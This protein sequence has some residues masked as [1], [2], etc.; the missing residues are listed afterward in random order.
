[1]RRRAF[2]FGLKHERPYA[3]LFFHTRYLQLEV[4]LDQ[5]PDPLPLALSHIQ[6]HLELLMQNGLHIVSAMPNWLVMAAPLFYGDGGTPNPPRPAPA[7]QDLV[8]GESAFHYWHVSPMDSTFPLDPG[9]AEN[10]QVVILDTAQNPDRV[11]AASARPEFRRNPLLQNL[12]EN[13]RRE[14]GSFAIE[15][16]RYPLTDQVHGGRDLNGDPRYYRI[17]DHGLFLAGL[18]R[19]IAPRVPIRLIRMLNDYGGSDLY[20]LYAVLSDLERELSNGSIARLVLNLSITIMPDIRRLPY[21]WLE[22]RQWHSNL[23]PGALRVLDHIEEGLRLLFQ[24]IAE[25]DVL[26]VASA[27]NDSLVANKQDRF[28]RPPRAP[29]RYNSTLSVASVNSLEQGSLFSNTANIAPYD[30]G[31]ATFGGEMYGA[32]DPQ[33][34]PDAVRGL[35]ISSIFPGGEQN[36]TAWA[37]WS[38]TSFSTGIISAL[39]AHL[40]AQGWSASQVRSRL[41]GG[42]NRVSESVFGGPPDIPRL[43]ANVLRVQQR[44]I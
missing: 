35:Y 8:S 38:G 29:A 4:S 32:A 13:L 37:D 16:D 18:I 27:G 10:V 6:S 3:A 42:Y 24:C 14:N 31:I 21:I 17:P 25:Y 28:P 19:D 7:P 40:L 26:I 33:G 22:D 2:V 11:L 20:T 12:A 23:L 1:M 36:M 9:G 43:L 5:M 41:G 39:S 34:F 15:Y 44:H 30:S